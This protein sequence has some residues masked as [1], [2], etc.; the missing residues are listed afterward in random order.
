MIE[1]AK[2]NL[3]KIVF[4]IPLASGVIAV[5]FDVGYFYSIDI[6]FFTAF[7]L[8]EHL[9]FAMEALPYVLTTVLGLTIAALVAQILN[10]MLLRISHNK[11]RKL[12]IG[13]VAGFLI[14][15]VIL[16]SMF[17]TSVANGILLPL[18]AVA[19]L[20]T[21]GVIH[22]SS[23]IS[24]ILRVLAISIFV[25]AVPFYIGRLIGNLY[26]NDNS[27]TH[28]LTTKTSSI[29]GKLIRAG[30]RGVLFVIKP[31]NVVVFLKWDE[32]SRIEKSL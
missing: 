7:S 31:S 14:F 9:V 21:P 17:G 1:Y 26:L 10:P 24:D 25:I 28:V 5:C 20:L 22:M 15:L 32:I 13:L 27:V 30:E 18:S 2:M 11:K 16:W 12:M 6:N 23:R 19:L 29:P 8:S 4:I 3:E